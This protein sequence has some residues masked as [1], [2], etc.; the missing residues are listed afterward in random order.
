ML[1]RR[2]WL[3]MMAAA[4]GAWTAGCTTCGKGRKGIRLACQMWSVDDLWR[5]DPD[6]ALT[7]MKAMGYEGIQSMAFWKWDRKKLHA[8]LDR[9]GLV[10]VDMPIYLSHVS[11]ANLNATLE[12]CQEFGVDFLFV[13]HHGAKT[14]DEWAKLGDGMAEAATRLTPHGIK[15]GFHNHQV[16][17]TSKFDGVS[18]MDMFFAHK[19]L[20][21]ELDVGHATLAGENVKELL[22]KKIRGRIPSIHAKPGGG[23]FCGSDKDKNDWPMI[24][25]ACEE[26]GTK[27]A[28]VECETRRNTFADIDASMKYLTGV[29]ADIRA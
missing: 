4:A 16:E 6:G 21:F 15:M 2:T 24:L 26:M 28:V 19:E 12:F 1:N 25:R 3:K 10:L 9:H 17:F 7:K 13:P 29:L 27:W 8:L 23:N 18:P 11:P 14:K 5:K 20:A 22:T